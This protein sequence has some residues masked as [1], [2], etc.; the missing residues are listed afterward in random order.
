MARYVRQVLQKGPLHAHIV[1]RFDDMPQQLQQAARHILEH[2]QEVALV[3]MRELARNAGVQPSTMTRL[4][5]FLEF[6]GYED[7]RGHHADVIRVSADGFA[8][9]ALQR[10]E[11]ETDGEGLARRM[12]QSLSAQ[13]AR[14]CEPDTLSHLCTMADRLNK[15]RRIYVLG[16]RS[17][18][19]VGWHF[20]YVMTLLGEKTVHLDAPA[21]TSGDALIRASAE[22]ILLAISISP[23]SRYTLE[24]AETAREKGMGIV[25]ITDSEVSPLVAI[26]E[27]VVLCPTESQT[28]FHT[29]APALAASEVLCGLLASHD[30]AEALEELQRA[31][32]HLSAMNTYATSIPR[33]KI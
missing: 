1:E 4:A 26:A 19:S 27:H 16:L 30:R 3:S 20:H 8:A 22:D 33:R 7:F 9:R 13:I 2:P 6:S 15:A 31:D 10:D 23:Y 17:C 11:G 24:L 32:R 21:G 29:L 18:H 25:A 12:L 5:K 28:F 14:M